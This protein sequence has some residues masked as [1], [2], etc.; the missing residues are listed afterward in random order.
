[1]GE[2][3]E[4]A[5]SYRYVVCNGA[6]GEP[7]TFKDRALMLTNPYQLVEGVLIA[8]YAVGAVGVFIC[9]KASF[10]RELEAVTQAVQE[11]QAAGIGRDCEVTIAR[12]PEEYLFGAEKGFLEVIERS[13]PAPRPAPPYEHGS[14]RPGL[15]WA[16]RL[17]EPS[18]AAGGPRSPTRRS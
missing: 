3:R 13:R 10:E 4:P 1:V 7:G 8:A 14:S 12:G 5:G 11:I 18:R 9:L 16:G 15:K 17:K 2:H 6:E